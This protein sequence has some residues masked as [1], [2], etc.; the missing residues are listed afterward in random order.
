[1]AESQVVYLLWHGDDLEEETPEAKLLGICSSEALAQDRIERCADVTGF[2]EHPD[3]FHTDPHRLDTD[4]WTEGYVEMETMFV[5][6]L[7]EGADVWRPVSALVLP[8]GLHRLPLAAPDEERW[9]FAP[10]TVVRCERRG[11]GL[12]A[13]ESVLVEE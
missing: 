13:V 9:A 11:M 4:Q 12:L 8:D 10:G 3:D 1:M 2:H 5:E 6:L 7:D